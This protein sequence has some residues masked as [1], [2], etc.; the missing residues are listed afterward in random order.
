MSEEN[1]MYATPKYKCGICGEIYDSIEE[2]MNCESKC[3]K[4]QKEEERKAAE[5]KKKAEKEARQTEV[6]KALEDAYAL[7]NKFVD[8][9]GSYTYS[10]KLDDV[11][12]LNMDYFP[13]KLWHH[14]WA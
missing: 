1:K 3:L 11:S 2:R 6:N 5:A 10:G 9:Y 7:L 8:D 4:K 13:I 12:M 14:F